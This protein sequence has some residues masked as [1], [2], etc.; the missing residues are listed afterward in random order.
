[1]AAWDESMAILPPVLP[2]AWPCAARHL[3]HFTK[4]GKIRTGRRSPYYTNDW[5]ICALA[6][7]VST[8]TTDMQLDFAT[9]NRHNLA[10]RLVYDDA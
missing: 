2:S 8:V 1:M 4:L 9:G 3:P 6:E 7:L 10:T 5:S